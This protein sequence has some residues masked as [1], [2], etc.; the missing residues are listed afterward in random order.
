MNDLTE[1]QPRLLTADARN[2]AL[3]VF[4]VGLA[5]DVGVALTLVIYNAANQANRWSDFDWQL[6]A[7]TLAKTLVTT[8]GSFILRR[9]LDPSGFPTP[10]PPTPQP[11]LAEHK[12]ERA[13]DYDGDGRPDIVP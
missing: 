6:L 13:A 5:I 12:P 3:R 11:A 9:F 4:L 7:F 8:A 1:P 2:R 10:L